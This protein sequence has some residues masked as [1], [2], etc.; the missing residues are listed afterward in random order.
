[1]S[2]YL[3]HLCPCRQSRYFNSLYFIYII[4]VS[5]KCSDQNKR[6]ILIVLCDNHVTHFL[7]HLSKNLCQCSVQSLLGAILLISSP[8]PE[9]SP[10]SCSNSPTSTQNEIL[11]SSYTE[12]YLSGYS[13]QRL[14][15]L[16]VLP[17]SS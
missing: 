15:A 2:W 7:S 11:M 12:K 14:S 8:I 4:V 9:E 5:F 1:M 17:Y 6:Y 3:L 16:C 10:A 13:A